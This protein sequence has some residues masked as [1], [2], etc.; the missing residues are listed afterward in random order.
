MAELGEAMRQ[1]A[2]IAGLAGAALVLALLAVTLLY[3]GTFLFIGETVFGSLGWGVLHGF[4]LTTCLIVPIGLNLAGG[5]L[6]D[7]VRGLLGSLVVGI[8]LG[9]ILS[10]NVLHNAS[11]WLAQQLQPSLGLQFDLLVW[12][13]PALVFGL[14]L[15]LIGLLLGLRSGGGAAAAAAFVVLFLV[16]FL[17]VGFFAAV[18]FSTQVAAALAVTVW[19]ILWMALSA[20]FA[21]QRGL[22]P[23]K[24]YEKLVPRE[25]M[26]QF[27]ATRAYLEQQWQRQRKKL[28]GR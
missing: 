5:Q 11:V 20:V 14:V 7:W 18:P 21:V 3:V 24:R 13:V 17:I 28:V 25:S 2:V 16:G 1:T 12:L 27:A 6:G 23:K 4:L 15:G 8:V 19:L 22:D 26:A 9:V 10:T